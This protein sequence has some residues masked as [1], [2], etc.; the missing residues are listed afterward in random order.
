MSSF[1]DSQG[2]GVIEKGGTLVLR[3][4]GR[5]V[6]EPICHC[7]IRSLEGAAAFPFHF[8][9]DILG[10]FIRVNMDDALA[11]T[12]GGIVE[13]HAVLYSYK[14]WCTK[15]LLLLEEFVFHDQLYLIF[16]EALQLRKVKSQLSS[17]LLSF[18]SSLDGSS[19]VLASSPGLSYQL[20][21]KAVICVEGILYR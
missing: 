5:L 20:P 1:T 6:N 17:V 4:P 19:L 10:T 8:Q 18:Q 15:V 9:E 16:A 7:C 11:S 2:F 21:M 14:V 3:W 12:R 13:F